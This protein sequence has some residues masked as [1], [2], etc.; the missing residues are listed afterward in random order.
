MDQTVNLTRELRWFEST[1][2]HQ[3]GGE[4]EL[5]ITGVVTAII[6]YFAFI[7]NDDYDTNG[8]SGRNDS[9]RTITDNDELK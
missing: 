3:I 9:S 8:N 7:R 5:L 6:I 1:S 4:M 2:P